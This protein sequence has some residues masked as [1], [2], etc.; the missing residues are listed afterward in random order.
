[1]TAV[2]PT[3]GSDRIGL[4]AWLQLIAGAFGT[5]A[6]MTTIT[7]TGS[8]LPHMQ[9]AF[10]AAPDQMAWVLTAF[11]VGTTIATACVGWL[12]ARL[13]GRKLF[14][15]AT[16]GFAVVTVLC[17]F[18]TSLVEALVFRTLQGLFGAALLPLGNAIALD[19]FPRARQGLATA[20]WCIV[21]NLAPTFGPYVGGM[22]VHEY[23][24]PWVFFVTVPLSIGAFLFTYAFVPAK[25]RVA[26]S[27]F[28]WSGFAFLAIAISALLTMLSRG[29]RQE[30]FESTEI[31]IE[32]AVAL[33]AAYAFLVRMATARAPFIS[34]PL[35][36]DRNYALGMV[37]SFMHGSIVFLQLF[38]MP[39]QLQSLAGYD[40]VG[41]GELLIYRG[42]GFMAGALL[43][44]W[45]SDRLDPRLVLAF[46]F[47]CAATSAYGMSTFSMDVRASDVAW[48]I[49]M[50]GASSSVAY[51]PMTML[52]FSTLK[53]RYR[54]EGFGF[55]YVI[56]FLGTSVGTAVIFNELSRAMHIH[57]DS[58][59]DKLSPFNE[60]FAYGFVPRVWS[61]A[62]GGVAGLEAESRRQ[63]AMMAYNGAFLD[64]AIAAGLIVLLIPLMRA[65]KRR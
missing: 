15:V 7:A 63:A 18:S 23:G 51:I 50:N 6:Y 22:M 53:E 27:G 20:M 30:W 45:I 46:G 25:T 48:T 5:A 40:I 10:S 12:E 37:F 26:P 11:L 17:G 59:R 43:V 1:M 9:G 2:A 61:L 29:E 36:R 62:H 60:L 32:G 39:L 34:P 57:H 35:F 58:F 65:P 33:I 55:Y 4:R 28:D 38:L 13:G 16:S 47:L 24:W 56:S 8:A 19:A 21:G 31:V 14:L 64:I 41:V 49:F 52:A 3:A 54:T 44:S 42:S